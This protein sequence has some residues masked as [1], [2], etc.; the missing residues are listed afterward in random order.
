MHSMAW[1]MPIASPWHVMWSIFFKFSFIQAARLK[2]YDN[3]SYVCSFSWQ[4]LAHEHSPLDVPV[5]KTFPCSR[6]RRNLRIVMFNVLSP[7]EFYTN[8]TYYI[9]KTH[10]QSHNRTLYTTS[11]AS[12]ESEELHFC[13][14]HASSHLVEACLKLW[15]LSMIQLWTKYDMNPCTYHLRAR[16]A[17]RHLYV[18]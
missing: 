16:R 8:T 13:S 17:S 15:S 11:H 1:I 7:F 18:E 3:L 5:V 12:T 6:W 4:F 2:Y 10:S 9:Y 14:S